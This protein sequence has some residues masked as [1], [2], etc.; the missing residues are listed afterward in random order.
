MTPAAS[1]IIARCRELFSAIQNEPWFKLVSVLYIGV[2]EDVTVRWGNERDQQFTK[3][4][5][6]IVRCCIPIAAA[7]NTSYGATRTQLPGARHLNISTRSS[8]LV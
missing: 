2:S 7:S 8:A 4:G 3:R 5:L 1:L 6:T